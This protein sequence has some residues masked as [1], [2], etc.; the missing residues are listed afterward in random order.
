MIRTE[1]QSAWG[2]NEAVHL[3]GRLQ[4]GVR[5]DEVD[6]AL[7][8]GLDATLDRLLAPQAETATF[9]EAEHSLRHTA[10]ATGEIA[11]LKAW[12]LYRMQSSANPLIEK[13]TLHW[14]NHF[15]T[16]NA[17]VNSVPMMLAQNDLFRQHAAG[18]FRGLLHAVAR[19]PA[20]LVWLDGN[21][22]RKRHPNENF[23]REVMELFSLG[24]GNYTEKDIQEAARAFSGWHLRDK[25]FWFNASQHDTTHKTIFGQTGNYDGAAVIDLC[26]EQPACPKFLATKLLRMFV[27]L[28]PNDQLVAHVAALYRKH[29]LSTGPVLKAV[30][31]SAEFFA[32]EHRRAII[33]SPLDFVLGVLRPLAE[34]VRWPAVVETLARLGQDVFE[35]PSVKGWDGGRQWIHST[36]WI[37]RWNF[38]T[39]VVHTNDV[40]TL[41]AGDV[42]AAVDPLP[43]WEQLFLGGQ[44]TPEGHAAVAAQWADAS[45]SDRDRRRRTLHTLLSLPEY[46]LM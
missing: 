5:A 36:A 44:P 10:L 7:A 13:L 17:K 15:A 23:A 25:A 24:I 19:D 20:M 27:T 41:R 30:C 21:A 46:Q 35:P 42:T 3:L 22:N 37:Q 11:D 14:H 43:L 16:S 39:A 8:D 9:V 40:A 33:K 28:Q 26:L 29:N 6:R 38:V 32:A 2:P 31:R 34:Q 4:F 18:S 12:W 1:P 45:G